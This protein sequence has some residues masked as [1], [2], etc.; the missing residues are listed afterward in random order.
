MTEDSIEKLKADMATDPVARE[1]LDNLNVEKAKE[2]LRY[3]AKYARNW[4]LMDDPWEA[5]KI[6]TQKTIWLLESL[7]EQEKVLAAQRKPK[8]TTTAF[9]R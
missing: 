4:L 5:Q 3:A 6:L 7:S 9:D 1:A 2:F 8:G